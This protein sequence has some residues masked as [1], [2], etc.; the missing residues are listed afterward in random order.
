MWKYVHVLSDDAGVE[1]DCEE[2]HVICYEVK[3]Q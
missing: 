2:H 3:W 1:G